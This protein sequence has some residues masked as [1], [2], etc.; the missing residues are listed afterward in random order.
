VEIAMVAGLGYGMLDATGRAV[1]AWL[2]RDEARAEQDTQEPHT[3]S[4]AVGTGCRWCERNYTAVRTPF[5]QQL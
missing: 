1:L 2:V 4:L 3:A 5:P